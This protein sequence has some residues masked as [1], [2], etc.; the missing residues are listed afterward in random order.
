[1]LK[2]LTSVFFGIRDKKHQ[3]RV[4][5]CESV[6]NLYI[7]IFYR[8]HDHYSFLVSAI[9]RMA[10]PTTVNR[11][12]GNK[13]KAALFLDYKLGLISYWIYN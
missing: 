11:D 13:M 12:I 6:W 3:F 7:I 5:P 8:V 2:T 10:L 9:P 4:E 1:M